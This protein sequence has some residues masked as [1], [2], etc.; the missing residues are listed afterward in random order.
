MLTLALNT[1][2]QLLRLLATYNEK[3]PSITRH[4]EP[5]LYRARQLPI[6]APGN[7]SYSIVDTDLVAANYPLSLKK[8]VTMQLTPVNIT[9]V[10][11]LAHNI[12][13]ILFQDNSAALTKP[14]TQEVCII[15]QSAKQPGYWQYTYFHPGDV[16]EDTLCL[17]RDGE[18]LNAVKSGYNTAIPREQV[19]PAVMN[20]M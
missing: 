11:A 16:H 6:P 17:E 9:A 4:R 15:T 10:E 1:L 8:L 19:T 20:L 3:D 13:E 18:L 2:N 7:Q 12:G 14:D 5:Y